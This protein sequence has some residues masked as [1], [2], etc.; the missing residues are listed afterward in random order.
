[1]NDPN[2]LLTIVRRARTGDLNAYGELVA[3]TEEMVYAV[4]KRVLGDA[5]EAQDAAQDVF[6]HA[7]KRLG[8][9]V[10]DA[11]YPGWLR[12][13]AIGVA[14][15]RLRRHRRTWFSI[16]ETGAVP[17]LDE[18]E[19][20]W[21]DTQRQQLA[22]A[23]AA[24]TPEERRLCDRRYHGGW[25]IERLA[26]D[27]GLE[28][29]AMR[30]R[31]QRIRDTLRK[32]IEMT[33]RELS[34]EQPNCAELPERVVELLARPRL[35]DL[36]ENPVGSSLAALRTPFSEYQTIELP[37]VVDL[38]EA[39][40]RLGGDAVYIEHSA[41]HRI[42]GDRVLRYDLSLPMLLS[43]S[44]TGQAIKRTSAGKVYRRERES[45][46]HLEAFHQAELFALSER[47]GSERWNFTG[48]ILAAIECALPKSDVR[49]TPVEYPMC[50]KAWSIDIWHDE[51]WVE[52]MAY[53]EYADWVLKALG[54]DPSKHI[55]LGAGIGLERFAML[56]YGI[57]DIR[58]I[59]ASRVA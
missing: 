11:A 49:V 55:A 44:W 2:H 57:D 56:R 17:V 31:L 47:S 8:D 10:D 25:S 27:A 51:R 59:A 41:L 50:A 34:G 39:Q 48:R 40:R 9:L 46:T 6:L 28:E 30:K 4:C 26:D 52:V 45:Q 7:F 43:V 12:S 23:L 13:I 20:H 15:N 36:P 58:K 16:D 3:A 53:G 5:S 38:A 22:R 37:E 24:L 29:A 1:M 19:S 54:A 35:V 32:D 14:N 42:E 33:E 21:S 18:G